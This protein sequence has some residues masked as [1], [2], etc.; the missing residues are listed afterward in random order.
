MRKPDTII[1]DERAYS[2][3]AILELRRQQI[4]A[5]KAAQRKQPALFDLREDR[6]PEAERTAAGRYNEP[7]LL[8]AIREAGG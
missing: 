6:R 5:W 4:E 7:T 2:W 8:D 1:I 3:R